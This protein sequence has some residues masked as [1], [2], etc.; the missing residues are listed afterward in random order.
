MGVV[1]SG[2]R[3][4]GQRCGGDRS[5]AASNDGDVGTVEIAKDR[6]CLGGDGGDDENR[7]AVLQSERRCSESRNT[8]ASRHPAA[9]NPISPATGSKPTAPPITNAICRI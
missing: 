6:F 9:M 4:T 1:A 2:K 7:H 5:D 8:R 3:A